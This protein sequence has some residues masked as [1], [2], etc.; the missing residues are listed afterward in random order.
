MALKDGCIRMYS[1]NNKYE[2]ETPIGAAAIKY[3]TSP[4]QIQPVHYQQPLQAPSRRNI[5]TVHLPSQKR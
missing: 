2:I 5:T 4:H 1:R 3:V